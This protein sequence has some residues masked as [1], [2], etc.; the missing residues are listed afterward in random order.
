MER[1][2]QFDPEIGL[3]IYQERYDTILDEYNS[4]DKEDN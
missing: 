4:R 3:E 1:K 2:Q